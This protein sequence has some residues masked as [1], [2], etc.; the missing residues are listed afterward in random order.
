MRILRRLRGG[1]LGLAN[2]LQEE[3]AYNFGAQLTGLS[4][5][6]RDGVWHAVVK[7]DF[8]GRPMVAFLNVGTFARC[9]EVTC[10]Y[11]FHS[12]LRWKADAKPPRTRTFRPAPSANQFRKKGGP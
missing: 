11:T 5:Y 2:S 1:S 3:I 10:E 12:W 4:F 8:S 9:V 6:V 7:A